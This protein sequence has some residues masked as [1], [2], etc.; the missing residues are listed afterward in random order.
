MD[1]L[2][3][4]DHLRQQCMVCREWCLPREM[5]TNFVCKECLKNIYKKD[6][7]KNA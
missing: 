7:K 3:P 5:S 2:D 1:V 4:Q 6:L